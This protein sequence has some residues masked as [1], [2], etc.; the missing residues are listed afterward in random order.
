MVKHRLFPS[1]INLIYNS[2]NTLVING[3]FGGQKYETIVFEEDT[4]KL[5]ERKEEKLLAFF[6]AVYDKAND[7]WFY[8]DFTLEL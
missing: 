1:E 4:L 8:L 3:S 6:K 2:K 7:I 5:I